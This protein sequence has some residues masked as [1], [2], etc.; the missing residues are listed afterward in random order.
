M[1]TRVFD[2]I[3]DLEKQEWD[4]IVETNRLICTHA[5]IEAI[6]RSRINDCRFFYPVVYD[7]GRI[8]A[9]ATVYSIRTELDTFARGVLKKSVEAVRR[10][11]EGFLVLRSLECGSPVA[12]GNTMSFA[13]GVD[14]AKVF[15][16]IREAVERL[17]G[18][19]GLRVILFRD[20]YDDETGFYD[21]LTEFGY[22]RV[23][24][25]PGTRIEIRWKSFEE[26][27]GSMRSHYRRKAEKQLA[28]FSGS[29]LSVEVVRDFSRYADDLERLW[30]CAYERATEYRR[31]RLTAGFFANVDAVLGEQ[32]AVLLLK[33]DDR[34]VGFSLLLLDERTL[35]PLFCGLDYQ[36]NEQYGVYFN[37]LHRVVQFGIEEGMS[38]IDFG[39]TTIEPKKQLGA[40]VVT[41]NMY[42]KHRNP[43]FNRIVP[44]AFDMLTPKYGPESR[45]VFKDCSPSPGVT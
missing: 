34:P 8:A 12:L 10:V 33:K 21:H 3:A 42:M 39:I 11:W 1:E 25:L 18:E 6:E 24:N 7:E 2:S 23:R 16:L 36:Y 29:G 17:A 41:L 45:N 43:L 20:F 14:R 27:L 40:E 9:H 22:R 44:A 28:L 35:I 15:T 5:Y 26:Y 37:L 32:S 30:V 31:E 38:D 19:L 4:E 13:R